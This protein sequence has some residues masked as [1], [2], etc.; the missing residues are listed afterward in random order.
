MPTI[1]EVINKLTPFSSEQGVFEAKIVLDLLDAADKPGAE[2]QLIEEA[3]KKLKI[4]Y[5]KANIKKEGKSLAQIAHMGL[6]ALAEIKPINDVDPITQDVIAASDKVV[7]ST[8]HQFSLT[9]LVEYH[10]NRDY[11]GSQL[12]EQHNSKWLL[13]P[14]TNTK[15]DPMDVEHILHMISITN[16]SINLQIRS[17]FSFSK[18][19]YLTLYAHSPSYSEA[20]VKWEYEDMEN[21]RD[22]PTPMTSSTFRFERRLFR[23]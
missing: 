6:L 11:R 1:A 22:R 12:Q 5:S 18:D 8:G 7:A 4:L 14:I 20:F 19:G 10:N 23:S 15:F 17:T 13:N 16:A 2:T 9:N 21:L 3:R